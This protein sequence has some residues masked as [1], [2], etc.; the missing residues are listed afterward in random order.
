[1]SL[2][3]QMIMFVVSVLIMVLIGTFYLN[4]SQTKSYLENQL[5]SHAQDTATSLGL[6]LS[7]V[8]DPE[9]PSSME[10]MINAVFDR[11]SYLYHGRVQSLADGAR[12]GGLE[13]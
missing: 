10:T 2:N 7:S 3:K 8:A 6:S 9:D 11:G 1:M 12:D 5:E 4:F 13:F